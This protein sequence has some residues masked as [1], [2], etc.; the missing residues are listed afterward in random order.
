MIFPE[1]ERRLADEGVIGERQVGM[2]FI[3]ALETDK[4][5]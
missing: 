2:R 4:F 5:L 1:L 3:P